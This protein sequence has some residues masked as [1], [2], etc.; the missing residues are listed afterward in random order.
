MNPDASVAD[1]TSS[2]VSSNVSPA[3]I[4]QTI[5]RIG[6]QYIS[7]LRTLS[8]EFVRF[9]N[10]QL[11]EKDAQIKD[12]SRHSESMQQERDKLREQIDELR[13]A[14]IHYVN[15]LRAVSEERDKLREQIDEL[16]RAS[17]HYVNE[18]RAVSE[19][20]SRRLHSGEASPDA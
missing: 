17:I 12:I 10:A 9:Y 20:L 2:R 16:R 5:E 4:E 6:S 1:T 15:E 3:D 19:D 18:L 7:D 11:A 14:S 8:D 13:R